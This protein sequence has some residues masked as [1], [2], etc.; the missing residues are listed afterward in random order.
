MKRPPT[1]DLEA[2]RSFIIGHE[3][4]SFALAAET[5][6]RS[7]SAVSAQLKKLEQQCNT[8]L[9]SKSGRGLQLT[10]DGEVLL[11]YARRLLT[12]NDEA[13][14]TLNPTQCHS[15]RLG[16]QE[17][18]SEYLL[19]KTLRHFSSHYPETQICTQTGRNKEL[20]D[21]I[22]DD[23]LDLALCWYDSDNMPNQHPF[24]NQA[25]EWIGHSEFNVDKYLKSGRALPIVAMETPCYVRKMMLAALDKAG[26]SWTLTVTSRDLA[27][28]WAAVNAGLGIT[29][30]ASFSVPHSLATIESPAFPSLPA[31]SVTLLESQIRSSEMLSC[32]SSILQKQTRDLV[33]VR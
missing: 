28:I 11:S 22:S 29:A 23:Q 18:F 10:Q 26:I 15:I 1:L 2:L 24:A 21:A 4:G 19:P 16:V 32:L 9:L 17:D 20:T 7:T 27:G 6:S 31:L 8:Q 13:F 12:L 3:L 14:Q 25:L 30:R 5:L 33:I